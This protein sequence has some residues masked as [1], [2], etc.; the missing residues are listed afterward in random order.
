MNIK[1]KGKNGTLYRTIAPRIGVVH[2][3]RVPNIK[4][5]NNPKNKKLSWCCFGCLKKKIIITIDIS[6]IKFS[7]AERR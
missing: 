1:I 6:S 3:I 2:P 4:V 5:K 7:V